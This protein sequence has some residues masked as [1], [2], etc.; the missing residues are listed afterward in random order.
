MNPFDWMLVFALII[1]F[2]LGYTVKP[3]KRKKGKK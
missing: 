3:A 1:G 2:V